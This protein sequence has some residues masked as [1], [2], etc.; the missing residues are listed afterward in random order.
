MITTIFLVP[1]TLLAAAAV[2]ADFYVAPDG[3]DANPGTL[4]APFGTVAKAQEAVRALVSKGAGGDVKIHVRGGTWWLQAPLVFG[5]EDTG[6]NYRVSYAAYGDE[7]PV[8][9][10]GR[11][12]AGWVRA[13]GNKWTVGLPEVK[14]GQWYFRQ[15]FRDGKRLPR[16]RYPNGQDLLR[17]KSVSPDVR[18]ITIS[19]M[20]SEHDLGGKDAEFVIYHNWSIGRVRITKSEGAAISVKNPLGWIGHSLTACPGKPCYLENAPE[21][22][23]QPG[24]W[25]LDRATGVLTYMA[26]EG[27]DPNARTFVAPRLK[28]LV[29]VQGRSDA[30]ARSLHFKGLAFEHAAWPLPEFGYNGIQAGHYGTRVNEPTYVLP[31]AIGL[32]RAKECSFEGC[33]VA[34]V[35][36]TGIG[37]GAG[38]RRNR[39]VGCRFEDVG[40]NGVMVGWR[41]DYDG[42]P[43]VGGRGR[44]GA[45]NLDADWKDPDDAPRQNTIAKNTLQRC[46]AVNHGA[47]AIYDA[48]C[49]ETVITRNLVYDM[50][51]TGMSVG[52]RWNSSETSQR[53][54]RIEGNHVYDVMKVLADGGAIY[55]LGYQ[56]GTVIRGN[57][58]HEVHRSAFAHGGAPNNGIFF[59]QGS[60]GLHVEDNVI[61]DTSGDPI[62]FNQCAKEDLT[63]GENHFGV[64]PG[65]PNF[66]ETI[67]QEAGPSC[68]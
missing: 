64:A 35:G 37:L 68:E 58:L 24:E 22:V 63:W 46:G 20:P 14:S 56:P 62:R 26:A 1:V 65:D 61:Y 51:Y 4:E 31:P 17:V 19:E 16:G 34:H 66:P 38:C 10:G 67:A 30:L 18:Q 47:V 32:V 25:Y 11:P 29:I 54:T 2:Q 12:I 50:P 28:H 21:F 49:T 59:D 5:P 57:H 39:I 60:K 23:D 55:T 15:L 8:L 53:G 6:A 33:R 41:S 45:P 52:F 48:F 27:E 36:A 43:M 40:G 13:G 42:G 3:N 7:Q 44:F 9:S